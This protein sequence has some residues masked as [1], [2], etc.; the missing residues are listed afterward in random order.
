MAHITLQDHH[1]LFLLWS[2][3]LDFTLLPLIEDTDL[4]YLL[5][6]YVINEK[7]GHTKLLSILLLHI[8]DTT[9]YR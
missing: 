9:K 3:K 8:R 4:F 7:S 6:D 1:L 2:S 5:Y